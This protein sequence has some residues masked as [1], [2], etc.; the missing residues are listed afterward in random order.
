MIDWIA[1]AKAMCP[2][3]PPANIERIVPLIHEAMRH[4][5]LDDE[6]MMLYALATVRVETWGGDFLPVDEKP[7]KY[8]GPDFG[9]YDWRRDL[10]NVQAGDGARYRGRGLIQLTGRANY[11][12]VGERIRVDLIGEPHR[13]N[14]PETA[15]H[16]L[17]D[18]IKQRE[19]RIREAMWNEDYAAARLAVNAAALG[20]AEFIDAIQKGFAVLEAP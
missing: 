4:R 9:R 19:K 2:K 12:A 11:Q 13:A 16:I 7:S 14:E 20:L 18:Y 3:T 8:T 5:G 17:A 15:A 6:E 1:I 10:G